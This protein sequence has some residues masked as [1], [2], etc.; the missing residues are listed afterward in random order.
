MTPR[1]AWHETHPMDWTGD[2]VCNL[3]SKMAI[4]ARNAE[5]ETARVL[6]DAAR[7]LDCYHGRVIVIRRA[8]GC[9]TTIRETAP[10]AALF[11]AETPAS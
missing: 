7:L 11:A 3:I 1:V 4:M 9:N 5:P 6:N 2:E 8:A 10:C